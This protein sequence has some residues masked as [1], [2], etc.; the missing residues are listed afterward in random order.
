MATYRIS[1]VWKDSIGVI[2][3]YC[4]H[5]VNQ[6]SN[7]RGIKI[8]KS[9]AIAILETNG[10]NA[11]TWTWNYKNNFWS[12]GENVEVVGYGSNKY[13]RSNPNNKETDNLANLINYDW[14]SL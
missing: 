12:I 2:T 10:N 1:G 6:T 3:H 5:T 7:S 8:K 11:T 14:L 9:E 4:F 13:L